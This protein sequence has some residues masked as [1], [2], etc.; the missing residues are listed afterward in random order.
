MGVCTLD[1]SGSEYE[2]VV[3]CFKHGNECEGSTK[4][5]DFVW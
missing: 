4:C 2:S 1:S 5:W 3:G